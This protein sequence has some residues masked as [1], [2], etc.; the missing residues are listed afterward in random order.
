MGVLNLFKKQEKEIG[1][2]ERSFG[3]GQNPFFAFNV[4]MVESLFG[5]NTELLIPIKVKTENLD[6]PV[7]Y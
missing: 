1:V 7:Y 4:Q 6:G 2:D 5:K 3:V